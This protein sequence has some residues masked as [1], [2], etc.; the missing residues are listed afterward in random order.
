MSSTAKAY[1]KLYCIVSPFVGAG[2]QTCSDTW[3]AQKKEVRKRCDYCHRGAR[4]R[5]D[6]SES[7]LVGAVRGLGS[8]LWVPFWGLDRITENLY[9]SMEGQIKPPAENVVPREKRDD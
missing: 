2:V 7:I 4:R 5:A 3:Q 6:L 9:R 8:A 1:L